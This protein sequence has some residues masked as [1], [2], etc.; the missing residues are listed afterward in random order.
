QALSISSCALPTTRKFANQEPKLT[1]NNPDGCF[2]CPDPDKPVIEFP[3]VFPIKVMGRAAPDLAQ[4]ITDWV[5][6][7][8]PELDAAHVEMRASRAGHYLGLTF[9]VNAASQE[10]L[11]NLYRALTSHP[12]VSYVLSSGRAIDGPMGPVAA[13][14][15]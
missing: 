8:D 9:H 4:V 3:C 11:D 12:M 2:L 5:P 15:F 6:A 7:H 10:R 13:F 1:D 14:A